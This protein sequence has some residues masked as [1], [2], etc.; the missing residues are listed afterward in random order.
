VHRRTRLYACHTEKDC[1]DFETLTGEIQMSTNDTNVYAL[2]NKSKKAWLV[3]MPDG[4]QVSRGA[5]KSIVLERGMQIVF[6]S[7]TAFVK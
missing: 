1:D 4:K 7:V 5:G 6:G 2:K 3:V